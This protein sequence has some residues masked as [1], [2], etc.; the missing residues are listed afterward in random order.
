[1]IF[2]LYQCSLVYVTKYIK[3]T[4][5]VPFIKRFSKI[6][7]IAKTSYK[8]EREMNGGSSTNQMIQRRLP[9]PLSAFSTQ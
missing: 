6:N 2:I 4:T 8:N 1:M 7:W 9:F 5:R 3:S